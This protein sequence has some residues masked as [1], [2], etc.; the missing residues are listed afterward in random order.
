MA[1]RRLNKEITRVFDSIH[2]DRTVVREMIVCYASMKYA[3]LD[4]AVY[5]TQCIK[6]ILTASQR[7]TAFS[8]EFLQNTTKDN[9]DKIIDIKKEMSNY[10][11]NYA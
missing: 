11:K 8:V 2:I 3:E 4:F 6:D 1:L 5:K 10:E 9:C 7:L